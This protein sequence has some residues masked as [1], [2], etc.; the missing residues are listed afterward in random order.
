MTA[1]R[2]GAPPWPLWPRRTT[3]SNLWAKRNAKRRNGIL[4]E[5]RGTHACGKIAPRLQETSWLH[6][7][8]GED[9]ELAPGEPTTLASTGACTRQSANE[10]HAPAQWM[11]REIVCYTSPTTLRTKCLPYRQLPLPAAPCR[12]SSTMPQGRIDPAPLASR[13][14]NRY[15]YSRARWG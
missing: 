7:A 13:T 14:A 6:M 10:L 4:C 5:T 9:Y 11:D 15:V 8:L 2:C 1:P 12:R 3:F